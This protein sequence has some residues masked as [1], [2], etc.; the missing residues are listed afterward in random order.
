M[1]GGIGGPGGGGKIGGPGATP[2]APTGK[3]RTESTTGA[4]FK[5]SL[6]ESI[7][8]KA[9]EP[10]GAAS[11]ASP[12]ERL[13]SGEIDLKTYVEI[14]VHSAISHLEGVLP[15]ADLEKVRAELQDTIEQDPD[16][17]ALVK[18]AEVGR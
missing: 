16:V 14:R 8:S 13:R 17:A 11:A 3:D 9:K 12:L 6:K 18:A 1:V 4:T 10:V 5:E 15:P 2:P 7:E